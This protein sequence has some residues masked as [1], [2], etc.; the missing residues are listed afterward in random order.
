MSLHEQNRLLATH[1][2]VN[3]ECPLPAQTQSQ[4]N[5]LK[6]SWQNDSSLPQKG[7]TT[8]ILLLSETFP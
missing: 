3:M 4:S 8:L 7:S 1:P 2:S 5:A 6:I